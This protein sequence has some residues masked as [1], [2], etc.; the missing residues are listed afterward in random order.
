MLLPTLFFTALIGC[1]NA[2]YVNLFAINWPIVAYALPS[3]SVSV[4]KSL[5]VPR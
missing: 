2:Q 4:S 3:Q 1:V 5:K